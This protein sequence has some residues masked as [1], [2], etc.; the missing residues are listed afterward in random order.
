MPWLFS[1]GCLCDLLF[2]R[3]PSA[4]QDCLG[5]C[6]DKLRLALKNTSSDIA[7]WPE[8]SNHG[9]H[10]KM[11]SG[12]PRGFSRGGLRIFSNMRLST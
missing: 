1:S 8:G 12:S 7:A 5:Q 2:G 9:L 4:I 3:W 11:A 10:D 6:A